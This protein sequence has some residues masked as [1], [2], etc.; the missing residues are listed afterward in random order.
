MRL[1]WPFDEMRRQ[2]CQLRRSAMRC[3]EVA[4]KLRGASTASCQT[5][6]SAL[7][8]VNF[9]H[10]GPW[11]IIGASRLWRRVTPRCP[12]HTGGL[13][14]TARTRPIPPE[15]WA[16]QRLKNGCGGAAGGC[17]SPLAEAAAAIGVSGRRQGFAA[18]A[19]AQGEHAGGKQLHGSGFR[20]KRW[21][22][23]NQ[24]LRAL[25]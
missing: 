24:T 14:A 25:L 6:S 12:Q 20:N 16:G 22:R 19:D 1:T 2:S 13:R 5:A 8:A 10:S 9:A 23:G 3:R 21:I 17:P 4:T 11:A 15:P 7:P 18:P